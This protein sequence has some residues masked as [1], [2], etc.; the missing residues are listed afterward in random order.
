MWISTKRAAKSLLYFI[1]EIVV[2]WLLLDHSIKWFL[3]F[4]FAQQL[5][6]ANARHAGARSVARVF[7][8]G[9]ECKII[10]VMEKLGVTPEDA[11][12]IFNR[13]YKDKMTEKDYKKLEEDFIVAIN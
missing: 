3:M 11:N 5:F 2:A 9:N 8:I 1:P 13:E 6:A 12:A 4:W 10:A 7:Q